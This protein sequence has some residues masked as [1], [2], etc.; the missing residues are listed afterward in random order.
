MGQCNQCIKRDC[1][2]PNQN[3]HGR[4]PEEYEN[5]LKDVKNYYFYDKNAIF[6][7]I[8]NF[9]KTLLRKLLKNEVFN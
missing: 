9:D 1:G 3:F 2:F 7:K 8:F 4:T 6:Q 5:Y